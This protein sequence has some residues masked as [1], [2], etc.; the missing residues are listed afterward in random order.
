MR[1]KRSKIEVKDQMR[2][3]VL[4]RGQTIRDLE[5]AVSSP[6]GLGLA[7]GHSLSYCIVGSLSL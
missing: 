2:I 6:A 1:L 4:G 7:H 3:G 5:S